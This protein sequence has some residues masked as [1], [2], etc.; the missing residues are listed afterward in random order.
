MAV[1]VGPRLDVGVG[2][3]VGVAAE[4]S[5]AVGAAGVSITT[6]A[7]GEGSKGSGSRTCRLSASDR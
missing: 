1:V 4:G 2:E 3:E 6:N 7:M 5:R